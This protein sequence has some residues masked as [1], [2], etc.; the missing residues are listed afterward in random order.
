MPVLGADYNDLNALKKL[1]QEHG[2]EIVIS[3]LSLFDEQ[4]SKAQ[5]NLITAAIESDSVEKFIP[6]EFGVDYTQPGVADAHPGAK[7]FNDAADMLRGSQLQYTRVIFGQLSDHYGYPHC[8]SHM[9]QFTYF[10]DFVNRKA[11]IPGDGEAFATFLHSTDI[12][13]YT[14]ALLDEDKWPEFSAFA[15][16][17][18]TWNELLVLAGKVTGMCPLTSHWCAR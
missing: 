14:V 18:L 12:A 4:S 6:S 2:V 17:R 15:S 13:K 7:W 9:K 3:T 10:M 16:D 1:L 11:G 5:L 8:P